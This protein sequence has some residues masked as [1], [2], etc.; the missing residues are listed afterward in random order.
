MTAR[1]A[2]LV[3]LAAAL[4]LGCHSGEPRGDDPVVGAWVRR[5]DAEPSERTYFHLS[6]ALDDQETCL[7]PIDPHAWSRLSD[8]TLR[9]GPRAGGEGPTLDVSVREVS[10]EEIELSWTGGEVTLKRVP[11]RVVPGG[12]AGSCF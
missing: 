9:L 5:G 11:Y 7:F 8:T 6:G 4:S 12:D 2:F 10:A 1:R 3:L